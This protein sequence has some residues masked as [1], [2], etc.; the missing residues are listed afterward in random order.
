MY[1]NMYIILFVNNV[2]KYEIL[3][4]SLKLFLKN[5][6]PHALLLVFI[7]RLPHYALAALIH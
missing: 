4:F 6:C 3:Y 5:K 7:C 1:V 2:A